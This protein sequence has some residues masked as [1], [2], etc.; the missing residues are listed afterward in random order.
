MAAIATLLLVLAPSASVVAGDRVE[1]ATREV[2][3]VD[4]AEW[5]GPAELGALVIARLPEGRASVLLSRAELAGLI[6]RSIPGIEVTVGTAGS[7]LLEGPA[8]AGDSRRCLEMMVSKAAGETLVAG[9]AISAACPDAMPGPAVR[10]DDRASAN[11]AIRPIEAGTVIPDARLAE[12]PALRRGSPLSLASTVG[13]VTI[14][15]PV[16]LAQDA[17]AR[18]RRVFVRT[19]D[20]EILAAAINAE[21]ASQQ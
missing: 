3:L 11:V 15:R 12:A 9:D 16:T 14:E 17:R 19:N 8:K 10:F 5:Q 18:D 6:R 7:I 13:P 20:G 21:G 2:R 1:L 4:I